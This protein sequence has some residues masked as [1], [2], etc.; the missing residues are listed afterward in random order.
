ML[1]NSAASRFMTM[2]RLNNNSPATR[3]ISTAAVLLG[4]AMPALATTAH[5][6]AHHA[7]VKPAP[8]EAATEK[9]P[10]P[11][12][13]PAS[14]KAPA[15]AKSASTHTA[16]HAHTQTVSATRRRRH[17]RTT[18]AKNSVTTQQT[19]H[20]APIAKPSQAD[21]EAAARVHAWETNQHTAVAANGDTTP[22]PAATQPAAPIVEKATSTDFIRATQSQADNSAAQCSACSEL[23]RDACTQTRARLR[24]Q[25]PQ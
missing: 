15:P 17:A 18:S 20:A 13:T 25:P 23:C 16:T 22:A 10:A 3:A 14:A 24:T 8:A 11:L 4:L 12:R 9:M 21:F 2:R 1:W 5:H 19:A 7:A 6:K